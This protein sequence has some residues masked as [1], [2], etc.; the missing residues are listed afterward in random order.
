M[1]LNITHRIERV[2]LRTGRRPQAVTYSLGADLRSQRVTGPSFGLVLNWP[3]A[4]EFFTVRA[5]HGRP[6]TAA[7]LEGADGVRQVFTA[8]GRTDQPDQAHIKANHFL[9][10][11]VGVNTELQL[12]LVIDTDHRAFREAAKGLMPNE[13]LR[14]KVGLVLLNKAQF[15]L[16]NLELVLEPVAEPRRYQGFVALDLGN[17]ATTLASLKESSNRVEDVDVLNAE[18]VPGRVEKSARP[19]ETRLRLDAID[20]QVAPDSNEGN[21]PNWAR[22][23]IGHIAGGGDGL[24]LGAKRLVASQQYDRPYTVYAAKA[25]RGSLPREPL[26]V[27]RRL[28]AELFVTRVFQR[29]REATYEEPDRVAVTYP[30]T[31]SNQELTQLRDAVFRGWLRMKLQLQT[32]NELDAWAEKILLLLDEASAA[33]FF[34]LYRRLQQPGG[35]PRFRYLYPNGLNLLMYDCGG[36]TTDIGL[37]NARPDEVVEKLI[38]TV[39]AR[40]GLR[41]FGGDNITT[42]VFRLLKAKMAMKLAEIRRQQGGSAPTRLPQDMKQ[43]NDFLRSNIDYFDRLVPT[44]FDPNVLDAVS[45]RN[46]AH[47]LQLWTWADHVK[48][49]LQGRPEAA[50]PI[51]Q[52]DDKNLLLNFLAPADTPAGQPNR[53]QVLQ[54]LAQISVAR[55]EVDALILDQVEQSIDN[56]NRLIAAKLTEQGEEVHWVVAAGNASRYPLIKERFKER[57]DVPFFD[58]R[59]EMDDA[60]LKYA[61]AKG[62]VLA[63]ATQKEHG[64]LIEFPS[65]LCNRLPFDVAYFDFK[66]RAYLVLFREH[67]FYTDKVEMRDGKPVVVEKGLRAQTVPIHPAGVNPDGSPQKITTVVLHRRWPGDKDFTPYLKYSFEG[68][69]KGSITVSFDAEATPPQFV[70]HDGEKTPGVLLA[71]E[72]EISRS[73]VQRGNL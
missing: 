35:L 22:W 21:H 60:N 67:Q 57:L 31:F 49:G 62:A 16:G 61:V 32:T 71:E 38:I 24:I 12:E 46:R 13:P 4:Y 7:F 55:R 30:T 69:V 11:V 63:L 29:F 14:L 41:G 18:A 50:L 40:S 45:N 56:C 51:T 19:V 8:T 48:C 36:G 66:A 28:P 39:K 44:R 73:P 10:A 5:R 37:V 1:S 42:E 34:F 58:D 26:P 52:Q 20:T 53:A 72:E 17:T 2:F 64:G 43:L 65:D 70:V 25:L 15:D 9:A 23:D 3:R 54:A 59:F 68:G 27:H 47:T 33:A 6:P